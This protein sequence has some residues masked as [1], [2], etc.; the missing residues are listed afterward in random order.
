[1]I[2]ASLKKSKTLWSRWSIKISDFCLSSKPR[3]GGEE[4]LE[5]NEMKSMRRNSCF[6]KWGGESVS[7][8]FGEAEQKF[9]GY[10]K[11]ARKKSKHKKAFFHNKNSY[12]GESPPFIIGSAKMNAGL[13]TPQKPDGKGDSH[14]DAGRQ[15]RR[16][17][18]GQ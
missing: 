8:K 16:T 15:R 1:M 17:G 18:G 14:G 13:V 10:K 7:D 2:A 6:P 11:S 3:C 12:R 9:S 5:K 4:K